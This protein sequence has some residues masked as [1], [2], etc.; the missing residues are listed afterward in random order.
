MFYHK[1]AYFSNYNYNQI[2]VAFYYYN[3]KL[4]MGGSETGLFLFTVNMHHAKVA[5]RRAAF[6]LHSV[7]S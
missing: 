2:N 6:K 4:Y 5:T 1:S 7:Y 3:I